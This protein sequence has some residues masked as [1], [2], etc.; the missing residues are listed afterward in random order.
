MTPTR[1][2]AVRKILRSNPDGLTVQQIEEHLYFD[3]ADVR[4]CL[5]AMP[6][7]YVDRW[8]KGKHGQYIKVW[9]CV[10]VPENCPHPTDRV[11]K[12]VPPKTEWRMVAA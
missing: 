10:V 1:Q 6:D 4:R 2:M 11:F 8:I 9:C 5:S 12:Y 7:V 3:A